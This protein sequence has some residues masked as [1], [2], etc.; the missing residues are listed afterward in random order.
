[1]GY[2]RSEATSNSISVLCDESR[3][4]I[5]ASITNAGKLVEILLG[6]PSTYRWPIYESEG[7]DDEKWLLFLSNLE[8]DE[9]AHMSG[10]GDEE[11][12]EFTCRFS[13]SPN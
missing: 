2:G 3:V 13:G 7:N 10:N 11:L 12:A 9:V 5:W 8:E 1:M 4:R 6:Y